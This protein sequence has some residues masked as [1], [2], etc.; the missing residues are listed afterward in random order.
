MESFR[1]RDYIKD[2]SGRYLK[3]VGDFHPTGHIVSY[4]KYFPDNKF[5]NR[6]IEGKRYSY[7]TH[8]PKNFKLLGNEPGRVI[9]SDSHGSI[10]TSTPL[11]LVEKHFS[12]RKKLQE[13]LGS[14][15]RYESHKVGKQLLKVIDS[16][17]PKYLPDIGITGSFLIDAETTDSDIDL[18]CYGR[19]ASNEMTKVF[20][21][22]NIISRYGGKSAI[23]LYN[24]RIVFMKTIDFETLIKQENRKLQGQVKNTNIHINCQTLYKNPKK[25]FFSTKKFYPIAEIEGIVKVKDDKDSIYTPSVYRIEVENIIDSVFPNQRRFRKSIKYLI[26]YIGTYSSVC[27][28]GENIHVKG[29]LIRIEDN[30]KIYFGIE[31]TPW[32]TRSIFNLLLLK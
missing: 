26:S 5:G 31:L 6:V 8:V 14:R 17:N 25:C 23:N 2:S 4:V 18:V 15:K 12:P 21:N 3:V 24:R 13:V 28:I 20:D 22:S 19:E 1:D 32:N 11:N 16:I 29:K 7:N 27:K 9:Y 10:V 30:R